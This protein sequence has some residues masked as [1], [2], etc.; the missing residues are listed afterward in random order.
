VAVTT[1]LLLWFMAEVKVIICVPLEVIVAVQF[2]F[3]LLEAFK[4]VDVIL[5]VL[6]PPHATRSKA[7]MKSRVT[8]N[9]FIESLAFRR[10]E[11]R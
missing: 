2:P 7:D 6:M 11:W 8:L 5:L 1:L 10:E 4:F 3:M 9:A